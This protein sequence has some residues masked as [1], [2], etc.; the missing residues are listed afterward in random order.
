[1]T[2]CECIPTLHVTNP[3][4]YREDESKTVESNPFCCVYVPAHS[5]LPPV[6]SSTSDS[7]VTSAAF[8]PKLSLLTKC[9]HVDAEPGYMLRI[10]VKYNNT[11]YDLAAY[12]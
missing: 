6:A 9:T 3:L 11:E 7:N 4:T 5:H 8:N 2:L 1:M 12:T 10:E